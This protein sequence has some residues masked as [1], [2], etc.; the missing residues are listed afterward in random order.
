MSNVQE[1]TTESHKDGIPKADSSEIHQT[2][3]KREQTRSWNDTP[4]A[5]NK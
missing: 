3:S 1:N 4:Q 2:P 5:G